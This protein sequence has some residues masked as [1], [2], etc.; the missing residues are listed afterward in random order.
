VRID[1]G[2]AEKLPGVKAALTHKNVPKVHPKG[3][4]LT[5]RFEYLL[6]ETLHCAGEEVAAV[7]AVTKEIADEALKLIEVEY[8]VLPAVFDKKKPCG[9][10]HH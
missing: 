1:T 9:L 3:Y 4:A 6:D 2:K 5:Y 8:E 10:M 7:A